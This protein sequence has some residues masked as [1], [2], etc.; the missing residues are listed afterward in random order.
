MKLT[1]GDIYVKDVCLGD[2]NSFEDGILT[3]NKEDA[4]AYLKE[5]DDH[6]RSMFPPKSCQPACLTQISI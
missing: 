5:E 3:I 6:I 4:I 1:I 2:K